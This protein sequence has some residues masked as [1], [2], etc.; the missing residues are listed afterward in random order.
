MNLRRVSLR[1]HKGGFR[2]VC[3]VETPA[4]VAHPGRL[5]HYLAHDQNVK[6]AELHPTG[7]L[8]DRFILALSH[9]VH[10]HTLWV[11]GGQSVVKKGLGGTWETRVKTQNS[12]VA[13]CYARP[14][15]VLLPRIRMFRPI[16]AS[17]FR[18]R[19]ASRR[20]VHRPSPP[21]PGGRENMVQRRKLRGR[22]QR[23]DR[24]NGAPPAR[25]TGVTPRYVPP[26][27]WGV[28]LTS[29]TSPAR[30]HIC[31]VRNATIPWPVH[32]RDAPSMPTGRRFLL[33]DPIWD[34]ERALTD[35][36]LPTAFCSRA[37]G[38][39]LRARPSRMW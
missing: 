26:Y 31:D 27:V 21:A 12:S 28:R 19:G 20:L 23:S 30:P 22:P 2:T 6:T 17:P 18:Y 1:P 24:H 9:S 37:D 14:A 38:A 3:S 8:S 4:N 32:V 35:E 10:I 33:A 25:A 36:P 39:R 11:T 13:D 16:P 29:I 34:M 5:L 7:K 15:L